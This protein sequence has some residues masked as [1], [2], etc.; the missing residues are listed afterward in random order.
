MAEIKEVKVKIPYTKGEKIRL[1]LATIGMFICIG[2]LIYLEKDSAK[3]N[4]MSLKTLNIFLRMTKEQGYA[5]G[6]AAAMKGEIRI[7]KV[8]DTT[9]VWASA[10]FG[11]KYPIK[12]TIYTRR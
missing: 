6:Q 10:P 2:I 11:N 7:I 4:E 3:Q 1:I 12:D 5:E 9:Y 8:N